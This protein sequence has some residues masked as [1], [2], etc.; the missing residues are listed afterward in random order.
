MEELG[1]RP[2]ETD[3]GVYG[4]GEGTANAFAETI[5][6]AIH[7]LEDAY[8]GLDPTQVELLAERM[9]RDVYTDGGPDP[10]RGVAAIEIACWDILGKSVGKPVHALMGGRVRDRVR[11][12]ANGWYQVERT[13]EAMATA[14]RGVAAKGYTALKFDPFGDTSRTVTADEEALAIDLI[15]AVRDAIG[16]VSTCC[17]GPLP[18]RGRPGDP[19]RPAHGASNPLWF[20]EPVPHQDP[21]SVVEVALHS[22]VPIATGESFASP[23]NFAALLRRGGVRIWQPDP[24]HLGGLWPTRSVIAMADASDIVVAPHSA[25]GPC[26]P[27]SASSSPPAAPTSSSRSSSTSSTRAGRAI[28]STTTSRRTP[29]GSSPSP[30]GRG[31]GSTW[32]GSGSPSTRRAAETAS[33]C[34]SAAGSYG[35][36]SMTERATARGA[37]CARR[38]GSRASTCSRSRTAAGTAAAIRPTCSTAGP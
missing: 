9:H 35:G 13:P 38:P 14:A 23:K 22:P 33:A 24:M 1:F 37:S 21:D 12:Y 26:A 4:V 11:V 30:T 8:V 15:E 10:P 18:I 16:P 32:T 36:A 25:A 5:A 17:G 3:E 34:S 20:E 28:S 2:H 7:E 27:R 31:S 6:T 29:T 19:L